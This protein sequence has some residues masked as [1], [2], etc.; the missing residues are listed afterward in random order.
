MDRWNIFDM[1]MS[2]CKLERQWTVGTYCTW[3]CHSVSLNGNGPLEQ[4]L[5][6]DMSQCKLERQW[7]VGTIIVHAHMYDNWSTLTLEEGAIGTRYITN[8]QNV[9]AN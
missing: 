9:T 1:D 6:M 5:Y 7:T 2:Q 3:T 4:L 8:R